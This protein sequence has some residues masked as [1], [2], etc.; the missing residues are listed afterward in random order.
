ML[1]IFYMGLKSTLWSQIPQIITNS[2]H[3]YFSS[4]TSRHATAD[5]QDSIYSASYYQ[6]YF[7]QFVRLSFVTVTSSNFRWPFRLYDDLIFCWPDFSNTLTART[8]VIKPKND[9]LLVT[10]DHHTLN[11]IRYAR[12]YR[13]PPQWSTVII[14]LLTNSITSNSSYESIVFIVKNRT[15]VQL[16]ARIFWLAVKRTEKNEF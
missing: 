1:F 7:E 10:D 15:R 16:L 14:Y 13:Q 8:R 11:S 9:L 4:S 3:D 2:S 6:L 12:A 5:S